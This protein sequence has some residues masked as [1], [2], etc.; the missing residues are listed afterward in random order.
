MKWISGLF[1]NTDKELGRLRRIV[2]LANDEAEKLLESQRERASEI[3]EQVLAEVT[4]AGADSDFATVY[5]QQM[6]QVAD[7]A[8]RLAGEADNLRAVIEKGA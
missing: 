1:D 7:E 4:K 5:A 2:D 3:R 6:N 8:R